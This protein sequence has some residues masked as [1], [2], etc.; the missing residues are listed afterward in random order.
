MPEPRYFIDLFT[1]ETWEEAGARSYTVTGFSARRSN[2]AKQI[3]P[4]DVFLCYLTGRSRFIAAL[5]VTSEMYTDTDPIWRSQ[6]FPTRFRSEVIV[7]V[8]PEGGVHLREVQAQS[9]QPKVYDWI[10][11]ASPQE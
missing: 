3:K 5:R 4:G 11:R 2:Y 10:F 1:P 9:K 7:A 6:V 8:P